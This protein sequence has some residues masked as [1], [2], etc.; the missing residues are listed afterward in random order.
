MKKKY[1]VLAIVGNPLKGAI[2]KVYYNAPFG[3][4]ARLKFKQSHSRMFRVVKV[5]R[6]Y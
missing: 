3:F 4:V 2:M 5:M 6:C 1:L